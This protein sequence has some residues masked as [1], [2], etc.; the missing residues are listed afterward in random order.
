LTQYAI[1][2]P[3]DGTIIERH[4]A[5]GEVLQDDTAVFVVADLHTV[6]V[7]LRVYPK[8]LPL[9]RLGQAAVIS[10]GH[11]MPDAAGTIAYVG[12]V[13]G[14]KTR[15]AL[16]RVV[17]PNPAGH[18]RPGL[19]VT[20]RVDVENHE[21]SFLVP[22][23][24]LQTVDDQP[25]VFIQTPEGFVPQPVTLGH[26]NDTSIEVTSG[27]TPGQRYVTRGAFTLKAQLAKGSF[28]D[29]HNH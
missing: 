16:A 11:G 20:A 18:W 10:A 3:F 12:P 4:I 15:T 5:L 17:L 22:K 6:W 1:T 13:V 24:A 9:V 23:T 19:F 2:A 27:L 8:D 28:G 7:D 25:T 14:A 29:G 21:V 26:T